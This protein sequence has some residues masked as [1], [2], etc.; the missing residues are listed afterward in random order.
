[1][2]CGPFLVL[3]NMFGRAKV[4]DKTGNYDSLFFRRRF[5]SLVSPLPKKV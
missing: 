5:E 3:R 2:D 1:M 4:S